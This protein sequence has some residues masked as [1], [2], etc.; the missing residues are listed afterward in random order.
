MHITEYHIFS[1]KGSVKFLYGC[2]TQ[3]VSRLNSMV[4]VQH[5]PIGYN[6]RDA[7]SVK[8]TMFTMTKENLKRPLG[9]I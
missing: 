8:I 1:S 5:E 7:G 4:L 6:L 3:D 2:S 9:L